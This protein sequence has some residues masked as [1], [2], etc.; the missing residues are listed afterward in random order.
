L[1][2]YLHHTIALQSRITENILIELYKK[3]VEPEEVTAL[4]AL[5][6]RQSYPKG[7]GD[8]FDGIIATEISF[9][10]WL[11]RTDT[12]EFYDLLVTYSDEWKVVAYS[13]DQIIF[14]G[15]LTPGEGTAEF[16]DKP[17]EITLNAVDGLGLLK[18]VPLTG[19]DGA[20]FDYISLIIDYI[21]AI[22]FKTGCDL[23]I[24]V[25]SSWCDEG[26]TTRLT[27]PE[28]DTLNQ[29][30]LH[31][32]TFLSDR[33]A[34][35]NCYDSLQKICHEAFSVY[36]WHGMWVILNIGEMQS[37][38]GPRIWYTEY[39]SIGNVTGSGLADENPCPIGRDLIIHPIGRSQYIGS[40][41]SIKSAK[42]NFSYIPPSE[43]VNNQHLAET[44]AFIAPLSGAS[45]IAYDI[46]GWSRH[47]NNLSN[48]T[49]YSGTADDPYI[50]VELDAFGNET[51]RY[52]RL[53]TDDTA[54]GTIGQFIRNDNHDFWV[55]TN[56]R[57]DF[58]VT[59]RVSAPVV[60]NLVMVALLIE[61][62]AGTAS[63]HFWTLGENGKWF[64][65]DSTVMIDHDLA[66]G[67]DWL[68]IEIDAEPFPAAG[69]VFILLGTGD[70][71]SGT[72]DYK[73]VVINYKPFFS[74]PIRT[75]ALPNL[76]GTGVNVLP[77]VITNPN[78]TAPKGD[79]WFTEQSVSLFDTVEEEIFLS[80]TNR[81]SI[82][83]AL[84]RG[85][86]DVLTTPTWHRDNVLE[87]RHF[88]ELV[89]LSRFNH[90]YRRMYKSRGIFS[91]TK[92]Q[93]SNDTTI[94]EP[95]SFHRHFFFPDKTELTGK[96]FM[97]VPPLTINYD[98]GT[99]DSTFV[100]CLDTS[101]VEGETGVTPEQVINQLASLINNTTEAEWD[102]EGGAPASGTNGFPPLATPVGNLLIIQLNSAE[103]PVVSVNDGGVGNSP[104]IT[105]THNV[106]FGGKR[107]VRYTVGP[108]IQP[109]NTF[110]ISIYGHEVTFTSSSVTTYQD[111]NQIGDTH[112]YSIS[113]K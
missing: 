22:L 113:F 71:F 30:G 67:T 86:T 26:M 87:E 74:D 16:Q 62:A 98:S 48:E 57:I 46:V 68:T 44:G 19:I 99:I 59:Y 24:R 84:F 92:W 82:K 93:P 101:L 17:Y 55:V 108:D 104:S 13:D 34:F 1:A 32:R 35:H 89:N 73:A 25:Y 77:L 38:P 28:K 83:G 12:V 66:A 69:S 110:T 75:F 100:E 49:P 79:Y 51:F 53:D 43:L 97:L 10:L 94:F 60:G 50:R 3:D 15:F 95:L 90:G 36:Q 18:G 23:P 64:N 103:T 20:K 54:A 85:V 5:S 41:L 105:L 33:V 14:V 70:L 58:S 81:K 63:N 88:K 40:L 80:D 27:D 39:D 96:Y 4:K 102:S 42:H 111:G 52:Y 56:D 21:A 109:G 11:R 47:E 31:K 72:V 106:V 9:T 7:D 78:D 91:G 45:H 29:T 107:I 6:F 2:Y 76:L 112:T 65:N 37:N 61:G 8:K